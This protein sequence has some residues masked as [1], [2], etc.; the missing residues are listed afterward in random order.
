MQRR[1]KQKLPQETYRE[2]KQIS[3]EIAEVG[4]G[5]SSDSS[6]SVK[7]VGLSSTPLLLISSRFST[8]LL[9]NTDNIVCF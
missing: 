8:C 2:R 4:G 3:V 5:V 1:R 7:S 6:M 9:M